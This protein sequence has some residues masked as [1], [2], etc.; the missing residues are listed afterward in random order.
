VYFLTD[1]QTR[2]DQNI[3]YVDNAVSD[4]QHP[5]GFRPESRDVKQQNN[6]TT[7]YGLFGEVSYDLTDRLNVTLAGRWSDDEKDYSVAHYGWG[8][9][10]PIAG[11]TNGV[12]AD[13]D[14]VFDERC[15]FDPAGPPDFGARFC[16]SPED[17][18]GFE[19]PVPSTSSWDDLSLKG[20]MSYYIDS[21][22]MLYALVSQGYKTGGFQNE[23]FNPLDAVVP[24]DEETAV[25]Y[26]VGFRATFADRFRLN[27]S[28]FVTE[29]EDLQLNL[30]VNSASGE[31]NQV[32]ANA[33]GADVAGVELDYLWLI[34]DR[35]RL[36][37]TYAYID[38]EL[39]DALIDTDGDFVAEDYSGS[40]PNNAPE[41][42]GTAIL[43]YARPF[44]NGSKLLLRGDWRG[45]SNVFDGIGED[46]NREHEAYGVFGARA[47]WRPAGGDWSLSVWGRNLSEEVYTINVGPY[48]PNLNQLNFAYGAPR[49]FGVT[50]SRYLF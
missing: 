46:S 15:V 21:D 49:R 31:Y 50:I 29:Y 14:G 33:A 13:G 42:T 4:P 3:F 16:G 5:S 26:E 47:T 28:A 30:Y 9:G 32:T 45:I 7:A 11:L 27:A 40:R 48:N 17:P 6:E 41:W 36:S 8:W 18:V 12:D 44:S 35:L 34:T 1:D 22:H 20:S 39:V 37:G 43:E 23:P 24:Y 25:N 2:D 19:T 38:A 10:G